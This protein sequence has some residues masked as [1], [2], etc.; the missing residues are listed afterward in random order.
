MAFASDPDTLVLHGLRLKGFAEAEVLAGAVGLD[1]DEVV[2]R[3]DAAETAGWVRYR[4]GRVSGWTLTA[5]GRTEGERRLAAEL[6][7]AQVRDVVERAYEG[8]LGGNGDLLQVCTE[9]QMREVDGAQ[10]VN[11]HTN[12][13]YDES[14]VARLISIDADVQPVCGELAAALQRFEGYGQR[15]SHALARVRAC[16]HDWFTKPTIDSYHTI[17]FELHENLLGTLGIERGTERAG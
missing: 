8:F 17:W 5:A 14:V 13:A 7:S 16:E 2:K 9:W 3:L 11:D 15:F 12:E 4:S 1:I 6:D 10:V